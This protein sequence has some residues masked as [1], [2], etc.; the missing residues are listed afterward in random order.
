MP[1]TDCS[2]YSL[3]CNF[4]FFVALAVWIVFIMLIDQSNP[5]SPLN[6][7][8]EIDGVITEYSSKKC[9]NHGGSYIVQ[10]NSSVSVETCYVE[11]N[12]CYSSKYLNDHFEFGKHVNVAL[13]NGNKCLP[14]EDFVIYQTITV[15]LLII[16][17]L[18][19][20]YLCWSGPKNCLS[21]NFSYVTEPSREYRPI[22][23]SENV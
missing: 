16:L 10:F 7:M 14:I 3:K 20:L 5:Y 13:I 21:C 18:N 19:F 17:I 1:A 12:E 2:Y 9:F 8:T 4:P 15:C 11:A 6:N 23:G 22:A